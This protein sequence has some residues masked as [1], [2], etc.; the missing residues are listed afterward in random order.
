MLESKYKVDIKP[1]RINILHIN[2]ITILPVNS[3]PGRRDGAHHIVEP[4][5]QIYSSK[6]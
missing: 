3:S 2:A 6:N 4:V 5:L 1:I